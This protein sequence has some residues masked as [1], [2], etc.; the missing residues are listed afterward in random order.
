[1]PG[2]WAYHGRGVN[3][4]SSC[5]RFVDGL[6]LGDGHGCKHPDEAVH[7]VP[8]SV[9]AHIGQERDNGD[10]V[11]GVV[12]P[13]TGATRD[14]LQRPGHDPPVVAGA[15]AGVPAVGLDERAHEGSRRAEHMSGQGRGLADAE[16]GRHR[17]RYRTV[18]PMG[19]CRRRCRGTPCRGT[20]G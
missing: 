4:S 19:S 17:Q 9:N 18:G 2:L 6:R 7:G 20:P 12:A 11:A 5:T 1:V 13:A 10:R 15:G 14:L 8:K 16:K 3:G